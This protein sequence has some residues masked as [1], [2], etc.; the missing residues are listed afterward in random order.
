L[1]PLD[2]LLFALTCR[3]EVPRFMATLARGAAEREA[4]AKCRADAA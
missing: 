4:P 3:E 2:E 1:R